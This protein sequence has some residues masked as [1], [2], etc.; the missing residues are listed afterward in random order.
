MSRQATNCFEEIEAQGGVARTD[1]AP[2]RVIMLEFRQKG[3]ALLFT[4][5]EALA[6]GRA[7]R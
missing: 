1:D 5:P 6:L 7:L 3:V 4:Y 2:C